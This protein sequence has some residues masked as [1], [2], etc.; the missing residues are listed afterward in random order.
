MDYWVAQRLLLTPNVFWCFKEQTRDLVHILFFFVTK[1][2][3]PKIGISQPSLDEFL[4]SIAEMKARE[5]YVPFLMSKQILN[6]LIAIF[7][8]L[9]SD[10][11]S[12]FYSSILNF[13]CNLH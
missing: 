13:E 9:T 7:Q 5:A 10:L 6:F 1:K 12:D 3:F 11:L 2:N 8:L 4:I